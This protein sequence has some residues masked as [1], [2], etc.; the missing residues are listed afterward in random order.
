[1]NNR[2]SVQD[3]RIIE[4]TRCWLEQTVIGLELC[5]FASHPF[6]HERI[7]YA[8]C[9]HNTLQ[10]CMMQLINECILLDN[11]PDI[12]TTLLI[13]HRMFSHFDDYLDGLELAQQLLVQQGYEGRYQLASFHPHYRFEGAATEDAANYTN[14]SPWPMLHLL[15]ET[16]V[17]H[18][19]RHSPQPEAIPQRNI[20]CT[21]KLGLAHMR[22][23]LDACNK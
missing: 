21:R 10:A 6:R 22:K 19:L 20:A 2:F 1:M 18:A 16:S 17:A 9:R 8:V 3:S 13:F 12:E 7:R 11:D 4:Q 14:R 5:P 15:R 23:L